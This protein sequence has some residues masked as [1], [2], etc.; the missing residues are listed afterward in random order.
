MQYLSSNNKES[1]RV[2]KYSTRRWDLGVNGMRVLDQISSVSQLQT[3]SLQITLLE[4]LGWLQLVL[5][6]PLWCWQKHQVKEVRKWRILR[7]LVSNY[8]ESDQKDRMYIHPFSKRFSL[9]RYI[10][11]YILLFTCTCARVHFSFAIVQLVKK[12]GST[13]TKND[14]Q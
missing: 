13:I 8:Q 12:L 3:L 9:E 7:A 2:T 5:A 1:C 6:F 4:L 10:D 11:R 14:K